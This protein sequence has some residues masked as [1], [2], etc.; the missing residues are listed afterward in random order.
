MCL[1]VI[2]ASPPAIRCRVSLSCQIEFKCCAV[3]SIKEVGT[4]RR[5][6]VTP[7]KLINQSKRKPTGKD[8]PNIRD[9]SLFE[10]LVGRRTISLQLF[11][12][13]AA[14]QTAG[15]TTPVHIPA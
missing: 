10:R 11:A 12:A 15:A 1:F 8:S 9:V 7:L 5:V 14:V 2:E 6:A 3:V 13:F 4:R